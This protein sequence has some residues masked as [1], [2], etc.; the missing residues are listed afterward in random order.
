[1]K[2]IVLV[3]LI[4]LITGLSNVFAQNGSIAGIVID[5]LTNENIPYA[6]VIGIS[7][8]DT[9]SKDG[10]VTNEDGSFKLEGL[11]FAGVTSIGPAGEKLCKFA[12]INSELYRQA[13][14][15]GVGAVMG[16]KNLKALIIK[17]K[18][19]DDPPGQFTVRQTGP[20]YHLHRECDR[21]YDGM[22]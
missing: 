19:R 11:P 21:L 14:R 22:L 13:G 12:C 16:S 5:K 3:F 18:K 7:L 8:D 2:N 17:G 4:S 9:I 20:G 10:T 6:N 1:M 15:G